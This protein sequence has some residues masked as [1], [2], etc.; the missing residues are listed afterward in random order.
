[1]N[2]RDLYLRLRSLVRRGDVERELAAEMDFHLEMQTRKHIAAGVAPNEARERARRE[3]G[4]PELAKEDAR[5]VRG[6]RVFD[7]IG[8]DARYGARLLRRS[9]GFAVIA[10][11]AIG[12]AIG[13]NVG[14]FTLVDVFVWRPIP[15]ARPERLVKATL[16]YAQGGGSILMSFPQVQAIAAHSTTLSDVI[17][18]GRCASVAVRPSSSGTAVAGA[19]GCVMGS[20]FAALGGTASLGRPLVPADDRDDA[21]PA[22]VISDGFWTRAFARAPDVVGRDAIVNGTHVTVAGV[23]PPSFIG[24][25]PI[26]PDFWMTIALARRVGATPGRLEDPSNRFIDV[27]AR[28]RPTVSRAQAE[29]ELSGLV[30]EPTAPASRQD[31][32]RVAGVVLMPNDSMLAPTWQ[33]MLLLAPGLVVVALVLVIACANLATLMLARALARQR[34]I[35]VRLSLGASRARL[36][37]QLLTEGLVIALAGGLLGL[38]LSHV[39]VTMVSRA[40]FSGMPGTF[41]TVA[42]DLSPSWHVVAYTIAL[43]ALAVVSFGLAPA[44]QVTSQSLTASLKGEDTA[45]GT[46]IRRSRFRDILVAAQ[47]AGSLVILV[48]SST[49]IANMRSF[50]AI[51]PR[52]ETEHVTVAALGLSAPGHVPPALAD[53]RATFAARVTALPGVTA[54]ARALHAPYTSWWPWLTVAPA[55]SKEYW[56][57]QSNVVTPSYFAV[58]QQPLRDGRSFTAAD[59]AAGANVAIVSEAAAR[60]LW[61]GTPAVGQVL[62][63]ANGRDEPDRLYDVVGVVADAHSGMV[64]DNDDNG[65]AFLAASAK[66]FAESEMPL[67]VRSDAPQPEITRAIEDIA[68]QVDANAP[69]RTEPAIVERE[70]M[71]IP[72]RYGTWITTAVGVCGLGLALVGLYGIVAFAVVQRRRDI[73]VHVAL[74][75]L[76]RDVIRL[77]LSRELRLVVIGLGIG[78]VMAGGEARLIAAWMSPLSSL[79]PASL[80]ALAVAQFGVAFVASVIPAL[81]ALRIAPMM[82]LRQE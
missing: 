82:V 60:Q 36:I 2:A 13:I 4:N 32:P 78:L 80:A 8:Q 38:V 48:A 58:V 46:R 18:L 23:M 53:S 73:A 74:G 54:T 39:T 29:A 42:L 19:P 12:L 20:Y 71:L 77:V 17:P 47:V 35:A 66:D 79:G 62:R 55:Q 57:L 14:F 11:I 22:I 31:I 21:P 30:V 27:K 7:E 41:G 33:T 61:P 65:Y 72:I 26:V 37:R 5:D 24:M 69:L 59:S 10:I 56:R 16:R 75:A 43:A 44:I 3:F 51:A 64:W 6:V 40:F 34:E 81:R 15:V 45:L 9:P 50:G 63:V 67:L 68:R 70:R 28:L 76:P 1:M 25:V 52:L 49:L